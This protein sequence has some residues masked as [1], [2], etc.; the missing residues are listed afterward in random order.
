MPELAHLRRSCADLAFLIDDG[1]IILGRRRIKREDWPSVLDREHRGEMIDHQ[2]RA[3]L[4][5]EGVDIELGMTVE[6]AVRRVAA[7]FVH[8]GNHEEPKRGVS[9]R[10]HGATS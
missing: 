8:G 1:G 7:V 9:W 2:P 3:K 6:E 10:G 4:G 5:F